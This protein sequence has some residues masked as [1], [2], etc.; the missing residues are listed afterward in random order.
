VVSGVQALNLPT[1]RLLWHSLTAARPHATHTEENRHLHGTIL[2][3]RRFASTAVRVRV[4]LELNEVALEAGSLRVH[5]S[6]SPA[7][8]SVPPPPRAGTMSQMV[9]GARSGVCIISGGQEPAES[10]SESRV[11]MPPTNQSSF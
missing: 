3:S 1:P 10:S 7:C 8:S 9:A 11:F 5:T 6:V 2:S 4:G